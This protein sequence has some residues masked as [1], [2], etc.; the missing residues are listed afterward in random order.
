MPTEWFSIP[1]SINAPICP[2]RLQLQSGQLQ[3]AQDL[4]TEGLHPPPSNNAPPPTFTLKP[5]TQPPPV[6]PTLTRKPPSSRLRICPPQSPP[7]CPCFLM[8]S[9]LEGELKLPAVV[10]AVAHEGQC[11]TVLGGALR[12]C[13]GMHGDGRGDERECGADF[14]VG[15]VVSGG[16]GARMGS[17]P[18]S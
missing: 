8:S 6:P 14:G 7:L 16:N 13:M 4:P 5:L 11:G 3:P 1:P 10:A 2:G 18:C 17:E 15:G 12:G 9:H